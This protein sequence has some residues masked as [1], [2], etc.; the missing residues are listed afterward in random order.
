MKNRISFFLTFG[1]FIWANTTQAQI[2][3]EVK[4]NVK[5]RIETGKN[6]SIVVGY[7]EDE[8]VDFFSYGK[9]T[10]EN[11]VPVD[12]NTVYEIGSISKV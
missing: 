4:K 11:G 6:I 9:T 2:S 5:Q 3:E 7:I 10:L 8:K 12:R 1:L